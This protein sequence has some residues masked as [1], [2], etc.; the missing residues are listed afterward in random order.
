[1]FLFLGLDV[2]SVS[3]QSDSV[4]IDEFEEFFMSVAILLVGEVDGILVFLLIGMQIPSSVD[5]VSAEDEAKEFSD[6]EEG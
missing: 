4:I 3:D 2:V 5:V 6:N 1:M